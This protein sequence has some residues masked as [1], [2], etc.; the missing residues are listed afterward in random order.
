MDARAAQAIGKRHQLED[1]YGV[2]HFPDGTLL[3]VCDGMGGHKHGKMAAQEAANSFIAAFKA[4][5]EDKSL[6]DKLSHALHL[7]NK[8]VD[9]LFA[10]MEDCGGC[11]LLAA[12]VTRACMTWISVG[13]SPLFLWR[14]NRLI[15]LNADHSMRSIFADATVPG[16][17]YQASERRSHML[18]SAVTGADITLID[19]P[20]APY[21]LLP[22]DRII[23]ASDGIEDLLF[24]PSLPPSVTAIFNDRKSNLAVQLVEA[25]IALDAPYADNCTVLSVDI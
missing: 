16:M 11:T 5:P 23:L 8:A 18:R 14:Q 25:T 13:D 3:V 10:H 7:A 24:H 6:R 22:R 19:A 17:S 21:P 2:A 20:Q 15:R 12:Y 9:K 4:E 1:V